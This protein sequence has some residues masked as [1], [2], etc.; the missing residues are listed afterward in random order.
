MEIQSDWLYGL[1]GGLL[2]GC[3]AAV[4]LLFNGRVAGIS[5]ILGSLIDQ[6]NVATKSAPAIFLIG[7]IAGPA[8]F[9]NAGFGVNLTVTDNLPLILIGGLLVGFGTRLGSGCT[10]GHGV[11]GMSRLSIRSITAT[12]I[13]MMLAAVTVYVTRHLMGV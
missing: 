10:S 2:I 6:P 9:V 4:Y 7:L 8:F 13:F 1:A 5:G 3:G 11:C 12:C